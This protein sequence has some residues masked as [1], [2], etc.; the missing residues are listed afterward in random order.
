MLLSVPIERYIIEVNICFS[1]NVRVH[2]AYSH[3]TT[4][5]STVFYVII[6]AFLNIIQEAQRY[7]F[8]W[9]HFLNI[10]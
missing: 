8:E 4:I 7:R 2:V 5:Q 1:A 10:L 3:K 6:F 9:R